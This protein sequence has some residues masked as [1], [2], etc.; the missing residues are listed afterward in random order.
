MIFVFCTQNCKKFT[1]RAILR[2]CFLYFPAAPS[3]ELN[4]SVVKYH[5]TNSRHGKV[6]KCFFILIILYVKKEGM[7]A[8]QAIFCNSTYYMLKMTK[9]QPSKLTETPPYPT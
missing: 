4:K 7:F 9:K 3:Q 2:N 8:K 5:P 1:Y 6:S